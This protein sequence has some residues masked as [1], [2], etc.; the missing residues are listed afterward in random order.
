[1][2]RG[3][4]GKARA[5]I[6]SYP[7][8]NRAGFAQPRLMAAAIRR[9]AADGMR[10]V[11]ISQTIKGRAPRVRRAIAAVPEVLFVV[12]AGNEELDLDA[13]GLDRD[14]C[15]DPAPNLIC[16]AATDRAGLA[17]FSNRGGNSVD[18]AAPGDG[19]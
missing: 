17:S 16:V 5:R 12:A 10:A 9:A 13:L 18:A 19:T 14:P 15:T 1:V 3:A 6:R 2:L 7:D 4:L 8:L 11:N